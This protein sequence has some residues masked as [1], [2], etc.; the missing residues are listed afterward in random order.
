[1][2]AASDCDGSTSDPL[3]PHEW[4]GYRF[5]S[6]A[7]SVHALVVLVDGWEQGLAS[8]GD[9]DGRW[10]LVCD[11]HGSLVSHETQAVA[12]SWMA[13]PEVWCEDCGKVWE[14]GAPKRSEGWV[15]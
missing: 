14:T 10:F 5:H 15:S 2:F 3:P 1:M 12:R 11:E 6:V 9:G 7:L 8:R 4:A 13:A